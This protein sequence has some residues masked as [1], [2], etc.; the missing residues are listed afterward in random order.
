MTISSRF[1][2]PIAGAALLIAAIM[3]AAAQDAAPKAAPAAV[4]Q[5]ADTLRICA[6]EV[7][8]PYSS[9]DGSGFENKIA[10]VLAK[11]MNRQAVFVWTPLPAIYLVRDML[12]KKSCDV[13]MGLDT[14]D[15]RVLTTTP[16]YR[17][18]YV[19]ITRADSPLKIEDWHSADLAK[20]DHIGFVPGTPAQT[21]LE[22]LGL[23][24]VHFNY[25]H[26][27]TDF[28]DRRNR[29]TRIDPRRMVREVKDGKAAV[30]MNFAP[31]V[32]RY[33]K[34]E[35][36]LKLTLIPDDNTTPDGKKVPHH[37]DQSIGVR[38]ED[39]ALLAQ[40]EAALAKIKPDIEQILHDE[41]FPLIPQPSRS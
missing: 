7:E 14:G 9:K 19:F 38:K 33:V 3:P 39:K 29:Y 8:F 37:F 20:A 26:S 23:F 27:L 10:V 40:I 34:A 15:D 35:K 21:M 6:S 4:P 22:Q 41:G 24:N 36:E 2:L 17:T 25:M 31:D 5:A 30:A 13:V 28:A 32:A 1:S 12:D 11:A 16:Y 18:G